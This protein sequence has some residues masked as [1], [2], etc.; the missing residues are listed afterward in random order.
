MRSGI[1][2]IA[3]MFSTRTA[4]TGGWGTTGERV[5]CAGRR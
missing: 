4:W 2:R 1:W 5:R 3:G